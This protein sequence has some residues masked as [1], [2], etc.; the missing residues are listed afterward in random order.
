MYQSGGGVLE[1]ILRDMKWFEPEY[2]GKSSSRE[3][4]GPGWLSP[5]SI[6]HKLRV[7]VIFNCSRVTSAANL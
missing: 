5:H 6:A 2:W 4:E 7:V 1:G 3:I